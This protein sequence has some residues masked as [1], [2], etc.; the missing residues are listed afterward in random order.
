M[1]TAAVAEGKPK[2]NASELEKA[3]IAYV[4]KDSSKAAEKVYKKIIG[5]DCRGV[6][7][8]FLSVEELAGAISWLSKYE[9]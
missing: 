3:N 1:V 8:S 7:Y 6:I 4:N 2:E 9:R 5:K